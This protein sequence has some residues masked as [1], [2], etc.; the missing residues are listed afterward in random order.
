MKLLGH[1]L[2]FMTCEELLGKLR[3][4]SL[5]VAGFTVKLLK[6]K[7][8]GPDETYMDFIIKIHFDECVPYYRVTRLG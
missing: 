1:D 3:E 4:L 2:T 5:G 8:K 6:V 7:K